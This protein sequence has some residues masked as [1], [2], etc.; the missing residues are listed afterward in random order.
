MFKFSLQ[1]ISNRSKIEALLGP[2][3]STFITD[4]KPI[5]NCY[6]VEFTGESEEIANQIYSLLRTK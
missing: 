2:E 5:I 4:F 3:L 1:V 6:E